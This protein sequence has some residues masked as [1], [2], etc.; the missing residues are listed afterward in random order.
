MQSF[1][2]SNGVEPSEC[3]DASPSMLV[4][5]S[6]DSVNGAITV[7][8]VDIRFTGTI[9]L[10]TLADQVMQLVVLEGSA[11]S[12]MISVP[13][14]FTMAVQL[15]PDGRQASG[16]WGGLRPVTGDERAF[17]GVLELMP[18]EGLYSA[19]SV[20]TEEQVT[21][22]L[23]SVNQSA[24]GQTVSAS[25]Q[26]GSC[27][28]FRPTSPLDGLAFGPTDFYWDGV[29]NATQYRV[30]IYRDGELARTETID[31]FTTTTTIDT[32]TGGIGDGSS[33]GWNVEALTNG[34]VMCT[35]GTVTLL[36]AA[37]AQVAGG[38]DDGGGGGDDNKCNWGCD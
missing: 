2:Y 7:N 31:A 21:A 1:H 30:N 9:V 34:N 12:D 28:G 18:S 24:A 8:G 6:P 3:T 19:L 23:Q 26:S 5:Q 35:T 14:G 15:Q 13:A 17:F 29:E 22:T 38:G 11:T 33:Y 16:S 27:E 32:S 37:S 10:R 20:P 36:R 4:I 25:P